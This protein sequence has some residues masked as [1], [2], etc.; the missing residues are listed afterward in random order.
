MSDPAMIAGAVTLCGGFAVFARAAATAEAAI[1]GLIPASPV[2][3]G[4][5]F[6]S[7]DDR[8]RIA[9]IASLGFI[10]GA[11]VAGPAGAI[12]GAVVGPAAR[13]VV[14]RRRRKRRSEQL[15]ADLADAVMAI[16]AAMRAGLSLPT[17]IAYAAGEIEE[18]LAETLA[19]VADRSA[20]GEP[21]DD[22]LDRWADEVKGD[23]ARLLVGVLSL[24]RRTGGDLPHV[25][26]RVAATLRD[27]Q[28]AARE[29]RALTAQ[30]RLSGGV[31]GALPVAFFLFLLVTS[32][33][34]VRAAFHTSAGLAAVLLG[35]VME[36]GAFLWIRRLLR[37]T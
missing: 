22:A 34:D 27:R 1:E 9:A 19:R 14:R 23:D 5:T 31:L 15:E 20:L 3:R 26:D 7:L 37:V 8:A 24:H 12:G 28:A 33:E 35:L 25:L 29:V 18:P 2:R 4:S 13:V 11:V 6:S 32:R 21:L 30:A 36:G 10:A 17:S 16:A